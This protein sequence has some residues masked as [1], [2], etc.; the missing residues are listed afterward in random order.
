MYDFNMIIDD[1]DF[2]FLL[3]PKLQ[4]ELVEALFGQFKTEFSHFFDPCETGFTNEIIVNLKFFLLEHNYEIAS[5]GRKVDTL[6][7]ITEG[8]LQLVGKSSAYPFIVL[9]QYSY[10]GDFQILFGLKSIFSC[11]AFTDTREKGLTLDEI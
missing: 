6:Y 2:Y 3:P 11:K 8:Y 1:F 9:P 4:T 5:P 7:F 10:F